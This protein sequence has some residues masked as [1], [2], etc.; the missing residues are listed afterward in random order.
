[1][2][3]DGLPSTLASDDEWLSQPRTLLRMPYFIAGELVWTWFD[4]GK[5]WED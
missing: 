3:F 5:Y 4:L 1:M 2:P